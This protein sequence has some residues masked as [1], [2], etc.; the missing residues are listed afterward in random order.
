MTLTELLL[1]EN[2]TSTGQVRV[3]KCDYACKYGKL[4]AMFVS[5]RTAG[6][7]R[8]ATEVIQAKNW[9]KQ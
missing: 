8:S 7:H 3:R 6:K 4:F 1:L 5:Q 9:V 2:P